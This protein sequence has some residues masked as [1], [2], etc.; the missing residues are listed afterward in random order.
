MHEQPISIPHNSQLIRIPSDCPLQPDET[1]KRIDH[2]SA[3]TVLHCLL[4]REDAPMELKLYSTSGIKGARGEEWVEASI[5]RDTGFYNLAFYVRGGVITNLFMLRT[6][7]G[8]EY[9]LRDGGDPF[10]DITIEERKQL[11]AMM[12]RDRDTGEAVKVVP[13]WIISVNHDRPYAA[14]LYYSE[15]DANAAAEEQR[16]HYAKYFRQDDEVAA[17]EK[18]IS[19]ERSSIAFRAKKKGTTK[20]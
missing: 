11:T 15:E 10:F 9:C 4:G 14:Q 7:K 12:V 13:C 6:P 3:A 16:K 19:R 17:K 18:Q 5:Q 8:S 20:K 1:R 2:E